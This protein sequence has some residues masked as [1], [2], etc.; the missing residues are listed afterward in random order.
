MR[1]MMK[2][3][4]ILLALILFGAIFFA[5]FHH[6]KAART[7]KGLLSGV[8]FSADRIEI[9]TSGYWYDNYGELLHEIQGREKVKELLR[10]MR[11]DEGKFNHPCS[12]DGDYWIAFFKGK[13]ALATFEVHEP[14]R[15]RWRN[16]KWPG[17]INLTKE[18]SQTV[19][20]WLK[21]Q[22]F[23]FKYMPEENGKY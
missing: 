20:D 21:A 5:F 3:A 11:F 2:I 16:G 8:V 13:E 15:L 1:K 4:L 10:I 23:D 6:S 22:G 9:Q 12:C 7:Y 17:D 14:G 19:K 18:S